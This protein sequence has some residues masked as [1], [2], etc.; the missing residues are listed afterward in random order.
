[1]SWVF[2]AGDHAYKL[3]KPVRKDRLDFRSLSAR[4]FYCL[5]ELRLNRRLAP[6]VYIDVVPLCEDAGGGLRLGQHGRDRVVDWLVKMKALPAQKMLD[7]ALHDRT[8][9]QDQMKA[10]ARCLA[11]FHTTCGVAPFGAAAYRALLR[12]EIDECE[13]ELSIPRWHLAA[14]TVQ[15]LCRAQRHF[16]ERNAALLDVRLAAGRVVEAHGD[17]R[18]EHVYLGEPPAI[19]DALEFSAEL[20][21][22]DAIDEVGF[23][24]L[25]CERLGAPVLG[26]TLIGSYL[27]FSGD[28]VPRALIEF[29]QSCRAMSRAR[30][31]IAHLHEE[32]YR[33]SPKWRRRAQQYLD[34]AAGHMAACKRNIAMQRE[35]K[36]PRKREVA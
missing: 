22:Q 5:E 15:A 19:I 1:M 31:A 14:G 35:S 8:A 7:A 27:G 21:M 2:I 11:D 29:H 34:L 3:K 24:A 33:D 20:R 25:E 13:R 36:Q 16:V 12:R 23:L 32:K 18:P 26:E 6:D 10:I 9:T 28:A 30:L 4:H 17:L